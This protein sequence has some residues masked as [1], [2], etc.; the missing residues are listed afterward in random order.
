MSVGVIKVTRSAMK[1]V[2]PSR[3]EW[4]LIAQQTAAAA[5]AV[6]AGKK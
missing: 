1:H 4:Q 5:A 6:A 2:K 3:Q